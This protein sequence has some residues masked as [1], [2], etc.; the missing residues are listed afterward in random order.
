MSPKLKKLLKKSIIQIYTE[1]K[2]SYFVL[3]S[4]LQKSSSIKTRHASHLIGSNALEVGLSINLQTK[5][6]LKLPALV[7]TYYDKLGNF[8]L[9]DSSRGFSSFV[10]V[11]KN[12]LIMK[13]KTYAL[14]CVNNLSLLMKVKVTLFICLI[15]LRF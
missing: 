1:A 10:L 13:N 8:N 5:L 2:D 7:K 11:K 4:S 3:E 12:N 9:N 6:F 15:K 14:I